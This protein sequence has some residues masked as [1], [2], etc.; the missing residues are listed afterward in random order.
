[1]ATDLLDPVS[2]PVALGEVPLACL[3]NEITALAGHLAAAE[4]RWLLLIAEFDRRKGYLFWE[5]RSSAHWLNWRCGVSMRAAYEHVRVG[6]AL[7]DLPVT[8]EAFSKGRLSYSKVRAITRAAVPESEADL[9]SIALG[10]TA[11]QLDR[12]A[13][14]A[15]RLEADEVERRTP[16]SE[17]RPTLR[18]SRSERGSGR[19]CVEVPAEALAVVLAA[20]E[21]V[22]ETMAVEEF[23]ASGDGGECP[24]G[25]TS[26]PW[27]E[28][29]G[30]AFVRMCE[31]SLDPDAEATSFSQ[32]FLVNVHCE[33]RD[34]L[35]A[36]GEL[37]GGPMLSDAVLDRIL[38]DA[39]TVPVVEIDGVPVF[40]GDK[41]PT[42]RRRLRRAVMARDRGCRFPGCT[43]TR[44][45]DV[46]HVIW[47]SRGGPSE[48][49][50]LVTLCRSH[51]NAVH[52]RGFTVALVEGD[53]A[54][55]RPD[56]TP[57]P[58]APQPAE[59]PAGHTSLTD[60]HRQL[61]LTI[62]ARTAVANWDGSRLDAYA[63]DVAVSGLLKAKGIWN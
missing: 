19:V 50:N 25:H 7:A 37:A 8:R 12:I 61:D 4:C 55:A 35:P 3:E 1:M 53:F 33:L 43:N 54:F 44:W 18:V 39:T 11:A 47:R 36:L 52:H 27:S 26:A 42:I 30:D 14:T 2:D 58:V 22:S 6:R 59:C 62:D 57:I 13:A 48:L 38:C 45:V 49:W 17:V 56:G 32:R 16:P 40:A 46:H 34:G 9:V 41:K 60:R 28:R 63:L 21:A 23:V 51:H 5:C 24:A 29:M 20:L 31:Q 10:C 15:S